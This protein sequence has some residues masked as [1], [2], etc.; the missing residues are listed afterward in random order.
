MLVRKLSDVVKKRP[1]SPHLTIYQPQLTWLMSI[2][3]RITGA[4]HSTILYTTGTAFALASLSPT[5]SCSSLYTSALDLAAQQ[6]N[7]VTGMV[8]VALAVP[9]VFHCANGVRHLMWD[10]GR[11]LSLRGVYA[12]GWVVN[13]ASVIG[14]IG[15][16]LR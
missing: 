8:K 16:A 12:S 1:L 4:L 13:A 15:L 7:I 11:G 3:H 6:P 10:A 9:F 2:G 5:H 14:G